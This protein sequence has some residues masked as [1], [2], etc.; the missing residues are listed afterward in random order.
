MFIISQ[1]LWV[2]SLDMTQI[3][4]SARTHQGVGQAG[5]SSKTLLEKDQIK[6][7]WLFVDYV[8]CRLCTRGPQVPAAHWLDAARGSLACDPLQTAH[9]LSTCFFQSHKGKGVSARQ[10]LLLDVMSSQNDILL[11]SILFVGSACSGGSA[12][13]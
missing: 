2:R 8:P 4:S 11:C 7:T 13:T 5:V 12:R 6:P 9:N 3:M 1:Y 10:M